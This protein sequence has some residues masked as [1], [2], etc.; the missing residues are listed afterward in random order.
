M[1]FPISS[2]VIA[3]TSTLTS[4]SVG[5]VVGSII[6]NNM[7]PANKM[8]IVHMKVAGAALG[9]VVGT[10]TSSYVVETMEN[11]VQVAKMAKEKVSKKKQTPES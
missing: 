1:P 10:V 2:L 4:I 5:R 9:L 7:V 6:K 8:D 3:S 11:T